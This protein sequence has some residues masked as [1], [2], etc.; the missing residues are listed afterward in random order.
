M[1]PNCNKKEGYELDPVPFPDD[2]EIYE[3][4]TT[5]PPDQEFVLISF[6]EQ[7]IRIHGC[8]ATTQE[9]EKHY[10]KLQNAKKDPTK[11]VGDI[12]IVQS[13]IWLPFPFKYEFFDNIEYRNE[14]LEKYIG[15]HLKNRFQQ[16][17]KYYEEVKN[18][19]NRCIENNETETAYVEEM[20]KKLE[21][22]SHTLD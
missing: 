17:Q 5:L 4:D 18:K 9:A 2:K 12:G 14:V 19:N 20:T 22:I 15:K 8:F 10:H 3:R 6:A 21:N 16:R 13:G 11:V 7:A 1:I